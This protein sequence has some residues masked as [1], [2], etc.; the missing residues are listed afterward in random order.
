[1]KGI[2]LGMMAGTVNLIFHGA[3]ANTFTVVHRETFWAI[4]GLI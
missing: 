2:V 1:M 3:T 4:T